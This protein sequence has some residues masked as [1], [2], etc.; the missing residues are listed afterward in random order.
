MADRPAAD[1]DAAE[2]GA[3]SDLVEAVR[4]R[5]ES[6]RKANDEFMETCADPESYFRI[7]N[8]LPGKPPPVRC[9]RRGV[10]W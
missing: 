7:E 9:H 5:N 8:W 3:R 4:R 10:V 1:G 2:T 6:G